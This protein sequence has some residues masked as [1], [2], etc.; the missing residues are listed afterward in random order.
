MFDSGLCSFARLETIA[1]DGGMPTE[2]LV[3]YAQAFYGN[4]TVSASR[5]Y[6]AF[7]A[8][9]QID[10]LVRVP[11]DTT[12]S[13]NDYAVFEDGTQYRV[14]AVSDVYVK[15]DLRAV[16]LTLIKLEENYN[17]ELAE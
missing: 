14:D 7:G 13:P 16:E 3:E 9:R 4:R 17:V 5:M 12:V 15:R 2:T 1:I 10:R 8:D 11:F 6:E